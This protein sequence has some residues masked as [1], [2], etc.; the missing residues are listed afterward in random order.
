[1]GVDVSHLVF[2]SLCD[3]D[4]QVVDDAFDGAEGSDV[5]ASAVVEFDVDG[6]FGRAGETDGK[7]GHVLDQ[8]ACKSKKTSRD[9][10][11]ELC[12]PRG[13]STVTILD[14]MWTLTVFKSAIARGVTGTVSGLWRLTIVRDVKA[15]FGVYVPHL[16]CL[17]RSRWCC[18][19]GGCPHPV[20]PVLPT[21]CAVY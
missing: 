7:M 2:E 14:L 10:Q 1:M 17:S 20:L 16:G 3:A 15:L 9:K 6:R 18:R 8:F 19:S 4:D 5:L 11:P 13:P 21:L 12:L